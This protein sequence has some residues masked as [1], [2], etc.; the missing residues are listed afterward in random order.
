MT[1]VK[2]VED[3]T[4]EFWKKNKIYEK[5]KKAVKGRKKFYFLD[6]PPYATGA[7]HVGT[8]MNK[9][10]KDF[11]IRFFRMRGFDVWDQP[12]YDT[13][14]VPIENKVEK[15]FGFKSK[16]DIEK[17]GI[18]KFVNECRKFATEFV[19]INS[20][21]FADLGV[22]M[23]WKSP[24][25]TLSNDYIEGAWYT[26]KQGFEKGFLY[27]GNYSVHVCPHCSTAVAYNEIEYEKAEDPSIYVKFKIPNRPDEFLLIWTTT[28]WT[29]PSNT[30]VM[31]NPEADYVKVRVGNE[32][33]IIAS[34][35]IESLMKKFGILKYE[36]VSRFKGSEMRELRYEHPLKDIFKFQQNL[37]NAHRIILSEQ[38]VSLAEGTGLVHTAP[39]HGQEDYKVGMENG[40]PV[41]NP[42]KM[43][44]TFN[45]GS[46]RFS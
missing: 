42:L 40:L 45:E 38:Y 18:G 7:I 24:Y 28:P 8:A 22:W 1:D 20:K 27:K 33:W 32:I 26:F 39:G 21:Q 34:H 19:G 41:I 11:F 10:L 16:R 30:G 17:F 12:G 23:D 43:D 6:G 29:I 5:V 2:E 15:K 14:G 4:A 3:R 37:K 46:G 13:H 25:L 9:V 44:G 36:I 35:T 31:V